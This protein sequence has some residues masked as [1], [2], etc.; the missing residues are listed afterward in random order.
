MGALKFVH[1]EM[2]VGTHGE[3][4]GVIREETELN[5]WSVWNVM[6]LYEKQR[7]AQIWNSSK[8]EGESVNKSQKDIKR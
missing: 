2:G 8:Y 7:R 5:V 4:Y 3:L 1:C 6:Y